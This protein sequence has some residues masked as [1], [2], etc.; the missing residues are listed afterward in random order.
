MVCEI[1]SNPYGYNH[2]VVKRFPFDTRALVERA[3]AP[4]QKSIPR[5]ET[6]PAPEG[7]VSQAG[8]ERASTSL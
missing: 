5:R 1:R 4:V 7:G 3:R 6:E 2:P 8:F